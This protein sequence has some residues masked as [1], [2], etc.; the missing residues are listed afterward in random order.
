MQGWH[1]TGNTS[2]GHSGL[3]GAEVPSPMAS[4][5]RDWFD[6]SGIR[7]VCLR[8]ISDCLEGTETQETNG[9]LSKVATFCIIQIWGVT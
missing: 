1:Y 4:I 5:Y 3:A 7:R 9:T 8:R 6:H 2:I